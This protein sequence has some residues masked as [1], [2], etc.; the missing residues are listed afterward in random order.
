[1]RDCRKAGKGNGDNAG[2]FTIKSVHNKRE[3]Q[4]GRGKYVCSPT[5]AG[6]EEIRRSEPQAWNT[7]TIPTHTQASPTFS[8]LETPFLT[9][10]SEGSR[11]R[12]RERVFRLRQNTKN[13]PLRQAAHIHENW[14]VRGNLRDGPL[15]PSFGVPVRSTTTA[16]HESGASQERL[17]RGWPRTSSRR[18]S[19]RLPRP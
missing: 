3:H 12:E 15:P 1:M 6:R 16:L 7:P 19:R 11:E 2:S 8:P 18:K 5:P 10:L 17:R 9:S 13:I 14:R 4:E